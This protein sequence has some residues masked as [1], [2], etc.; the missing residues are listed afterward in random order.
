MEGPPRISEEEVFHPFNETAEKALLEINRLWEIIND[1]EGLPLS[2][3]PAYDWGVELLTENAFEY[4]RA[5]FDMAKSSE[6]EERFR[7]A[8]GLK[9]LLM[10]LRSEERGEVLKSLLT[11][12]EAIEELVRKAQ[13][14][15]PKGLQIKEKFEPI[16]DFL[17]MLRKR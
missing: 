1:P 9:R 11:T 10:V 12:N 5:L 2:V 15:L 16:K 4:G 3:D 17:R 14:E 8:R 6:G 13:E 7:Y